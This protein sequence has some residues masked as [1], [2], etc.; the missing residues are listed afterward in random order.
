MEIT[1]ISVKSGEV[2]AYRETNGGMDYIKA[3]GKHTFP[4]LLDQQQ[5][6]LD[7]VCVHIKQNNFDTCRNSYDDGQYDNRNGYN[8]VYNT[9]LWEFENC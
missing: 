1:N 2:I 6:W 8:Q 4:T 3:E 5:E 7:Q 9:Y